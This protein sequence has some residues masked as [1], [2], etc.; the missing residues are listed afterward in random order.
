MKQPALTAA[1]PLL[2]CPNKAAWSAWLG[3]NYE[4]SPGV[5]LVIAKG[6]SSEP[7]VTYP[8]AVESALCH[9]W[10]DGQKKT[11]DKD[12][13]LQKFTRRG[14][15]S[16]WSK[17]NREKALALIERNEMRPAGLAEVERA[18]Q[19]GRW[20]AAY[21]PPSRSTVPEDFQVALDGSPDAK[22]FWSTLNSAN[23]YAVLFRIQTVK[24]A[25]TRAKRI[26]Q[27][28]AMLKRGEKLHP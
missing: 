9:G 14:K 24:R 10:I 2:H 8:E 23:R 19:D 17:I 13:W 20:E 22:A 16:I 21:D 11:H 5:W 3:S 1:L 7:S 26:E 4:Q 27:F 15:K 6:T 25:E 12:S 18:R 28:V